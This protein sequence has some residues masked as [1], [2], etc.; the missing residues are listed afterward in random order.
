[1]K[2]PNTVEELTALLERCGVSIESWGTGK[3]KTVGHLLEE[4]VLE[5]AFLVDTPDGRL[6]RE[7]AVVCLDI[8]A[9]AL[10]LKEAY[11]LFYRDGRRRER[12]LDAT[13]GEKMRPGETPHDAVQRLIR[14]EFPVLLLQPAEDLKEGKT[15][16]RESESKSYTGLPTRYR[17]HFFSIEL[18]IELPAFT[19]LEPDKMSAY[20]WVERRDVMPH[21]P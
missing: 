2:K 12:E 3:A 9:G 14:E 7:T 20:E 10:V 15:A 13:T 11:Q 17:L 6:V 18:R 21:P 4:L 19:V 8:S 1:M 5:E 16:L